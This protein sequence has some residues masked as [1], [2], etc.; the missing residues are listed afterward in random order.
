MSA[1]ERNAGVR[2][3]RL[4]ALQHCGNHVMRQHVDRHSDDGE[5]HQR[6][7]AHC[8]DVGERVGRR[9]AAEVERIVDD[10]HEEVCGRDD[11]LLVVQLVD[12]GVVGGIVADEQVREERQRRAAFEQVSEQ[13]G[14][15]FAAAPAAV[16]QAGEAGRGAC[17]GLKVD[18]CGANL[19]LRMIAL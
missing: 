15:D 12:G 7:A 11:R 9:N 3:H 4:A 2:A 16:R 1:R 14:G 6:F 10:R 17:L 18:H 13:A 8:I 19:W 5:R